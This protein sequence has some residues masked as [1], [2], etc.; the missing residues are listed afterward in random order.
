MVL[1]LLRLCQDDGGD[2]LDDLLQHLRAR[3]ADLVAADSHE[4]PNTEASELNQPT[5][6]DGSG[7]PEA[8]S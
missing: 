6:V 3:H 8:G 5:D 1:N 2:K 4:A 7:P